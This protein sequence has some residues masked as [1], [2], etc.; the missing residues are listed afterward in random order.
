[1]KKANYVLISNLA[2]P[3]VIMLTGWG[4]AGKRAEAQGT[5]GHSGEHQQ[6]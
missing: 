6:T 2:L 5:A 4:C 3:L 1:M